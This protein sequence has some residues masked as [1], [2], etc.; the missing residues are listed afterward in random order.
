MLN[1]R[2]PV[3]PL[4]ANCYVLACPETRRGVV[5]DPGGDV[6]DILE[7]VEAEQVAVEH[8]LL[9]HG[10]FDHCY[11]APELARATGAPVWLH[12][13]DREMAEQPNAIFMA[14]MGFEARTVPIDR[15]YD[16]G[17]RVEVGT[18]AFEVLHTPGHSPGSVC[19]RVAGHLLTG[20]TLFAGSVGR[21]DLPGGDGPT[22]GRSL[23]RLRELPGDLIVLTGHE[24]PTTLER[25]QRANPFL[26]GQITL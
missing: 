14:C 25:E 15:T 7:R 16:E 12:E 21:T 13:G 9:T 5:V 26:T 10:H 19:L 24:Q 18:L 2:L 22:L 8:I 1:V 11:G 3:A 20:D 17:D 6:P 4:G 23:Q